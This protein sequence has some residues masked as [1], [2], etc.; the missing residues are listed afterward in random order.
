MAHFQNLLNKCTDFC[1]KLAQYLCPCFYAYTENEPNYDEY[2]E[3]V[4]VVELEE[5]VVDRQ[6][7]DSVQDQDE[8]YDTNTDSS[9][10][11]VLINA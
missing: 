9:D 6:D 5:V 11:F 10:E 7:S 1:S 8:V 3:T 2:E 4:K